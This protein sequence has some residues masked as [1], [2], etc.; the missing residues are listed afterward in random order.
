MEEKYASKDVV[1]ETVVVEVVEV[2]KAEETMTKYVYNIKENIS[3]KDVLPIFTVQ[4]DKQPMVEDAMAEAVVEPMV[5]DANP[6]IQTAIINIYLLH[7]DKG[8]YCHLHQYH[9]L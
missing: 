4:Q 9:K 6:I 3:G 8:V 5:E 1:V 7:R 2:D